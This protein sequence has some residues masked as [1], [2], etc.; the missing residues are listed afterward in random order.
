MRHAALAVLFLPLAFA[1]SDREKAGPVP[2][3]AAAEPTAVERQ[4]FTLVA[5]GDNRGKIAPCGC[6]P[7]AGGLP[8][9]VA[10]VQ[11]LRS[12]GPVLVVD[13]GDAL[14][15]DPRRPDPESARLILSAMAATGVAAGAVGEFDLVL[16]ISWL[17]EEAEK[18]GVPLLSAN[19][20]DAS[21]EAP[22]PGRKI[23]E[24]GGNRVGIFSVLTSARSLPDD[25]TLTD[26]A[27]AAARE[28]AALREEGVDLIVGLVHGPM[29]EVNQLARNVTVDIVVPA[30]QGGNTRAYPQGDGWILYSGYE[31]RTLLEA[32][33]DLRGEGA[34]VSLDELERHR[35]SREEL[36]RKIE[37]G[38]KQ[39]PTLAVAAQRAE[40]EELVAGFRR[41]L[42]RLDRER[43]YL[44]EDRGRNFRSRLISLD[45]S[46]GEDATFLEEVRKLEAR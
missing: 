25:L 40:V 3:T 7:P 44:G 34:L 14:V 41:D 2:P 30:H 4:P 24:V 38:E 1:C 35:R 29:R 21:G 27:A 12:E 6:Q 8:R 36:E 13:A 46:L 15:T 43:E 9:R 33:I 45:G 32:K 23:V 39:L 17:K 5:T 37:F 22:F 20:R 42:R 31:G 10:A 18:A 11:K 19:L 26:A 16:G 28:V